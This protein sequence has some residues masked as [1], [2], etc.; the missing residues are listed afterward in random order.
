MRRATALVFI[1][2]I[3]ACGGAPA[4]SGAPSTAPTLAA[5]AAPTPT[6][7]PTKL[8]VTYGSVAADVLPT[9]VALDSGIFLRNGLDVELQLI[10]SSSAAVAALVSAKADF[11]QAGGSEIISAN[12]GGADLVSLAMTS[13]TYSYVLEASPDIKTPAE[14]KGKK[15]GISSAGSSSDV[16]VRVSLKKI[17]LDPDKDVSIV[18]IGGIPER[19]AAMQSGAIQATVA[20]PPETIALERAGFKPL[21]DLASLKLPAALQGTIT[22]RDMV[23]AKKDVVQRYV[24]SIVQSIAYIRKNRQAAIDVLKKYFKSTDDAAMGAT[25]DFYV[26]EVWQPLPAPRPELFGDALTTLAAKNDKVKGYDVTKMIDASFVQK[27]GE[28]GLDK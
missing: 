25:V 23:T 14:L 10:T 17:G 3:V 4:A 21:L 11:A 5:S 27:A 24:D 1:L 26:N 6:T 8:V 7:A 12:V 28:R 9:Y 19:T 20:N 18:A 15:V 2:G 13:S 16:A 22:R